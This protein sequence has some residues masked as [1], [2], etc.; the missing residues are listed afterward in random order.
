[1]GIGGAGFRVG[2]LLG[3]AEGNRGRE[4]EVMMRRERED[5]S[6][7]LEVEH[8]TTGGLRFRGLGFKV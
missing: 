1:M 3:E 7:T 6:S 8:M 5:V 4:E 2:P